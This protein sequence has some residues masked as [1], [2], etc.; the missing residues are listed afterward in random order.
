M[1]NK[2]TFA[3]LVVAY[4]ASLFLAAP[5]Q[6]AGNLVFDINYT[7]ECQETSPNNAN[8]GVKQHV[9]VTLHDGNRVTE[10]RSW[11]SPKTTGGLASEGAIRAGFCRRIPVFTTPASESP[12]R[13][14]VRSRLETVEM[15]SVRA[16]MVAQ[17]TW[18][19]SGYR[20]RFGARVGKPAVLHVGDDDRRAPVGQMAGRPGFRNPEISLGYLVRAGSG[21]RT[22]ARITH[23]DYELS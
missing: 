5:A 1:R 4:S 17:A 6:A 11:Q 18:R 7:D 21:S 12:R 2:T 16:E 19:W 23:L 22:T 15:S 10:Q 9:V 13:F 3:S 8:Y 14:G 20:D